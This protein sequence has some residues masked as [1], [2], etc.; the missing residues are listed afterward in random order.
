[1]AV[2]VVTGATGGIG[3]W[4]ALG[5]AAAGHEVVLVGR[6]RGRG[7]AA[8]A[9]IGSRIPGANTTLLVS[10]LSSLAATRQA[11][12]LID[13]RYPAVDVLVNN[14]GVF[15]AGR[16]VTAEGHERVI[17]TNHLC[18]F[19]L[20]RVLTPALRAA[21]SANGSAR[22]VTVGSSMSDRARIDPDALE[23]ER[24]WGRVRAYGQSKLAVMMTS[25]G[26]GKR[27][28]GSGVVS[29]VVHPGAVATKLVRAGGTVGI[30]WRVMAPFLLTEENGADTPLHAALAPE[31]GRLSGQYLKK[32]RAVEPNRRVRD[33]AL[34]ERVWAATET[35][36]GG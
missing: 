22:I 18:P 16:E 10:D 26:W 5:L 19:V 23:L 24:G 11:G 28:E 17:A 1:M 8:Q 7:E 20:T 21:A 34:A 6:D 31:F 13:A 36:V 15:T 33:A 9:W 14:A 35:L 27:L 12:I 32:R 29:N 4:I 2:S 25:F 3:R 30:A